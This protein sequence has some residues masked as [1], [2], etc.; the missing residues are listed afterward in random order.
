MAL[1]NLYIFD[2][3]LPVAPMRVI[4]EESG[5]RTF[6]VKIDRCD[7]VEF[8]KCRIEEQH[9]H[10]ESWQKLMYK[11]RVCTQL[12]SHDCFINNDLKFDGLPITF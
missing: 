9:H 7:K 2:F 12:L 11:G 8:L 10:P 6:E 1:R 5:G 3:S 4:I